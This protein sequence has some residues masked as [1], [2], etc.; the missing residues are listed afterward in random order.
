MAENKEELSIE[1]MFDRLDGIMR[2]LEDS[3]STLEESFAS[4]E[5]GMRL[6]RACSEKIDKVE[7][8]IMVVNGEET[9]ARQRWK[10]QRNGWHR[11][12]KKRKRLYIL[13]FRQRK[14]IRKRSLKR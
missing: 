3:R 7:K 13:I 6:V 9:E 8:Q 14:G 12:S 11:Q 4:Y 5:A 1:E 2:T 10:M